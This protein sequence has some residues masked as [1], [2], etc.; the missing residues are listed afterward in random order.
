MDTNTIV[1]PESLASLQL[2]LGLTNS[3]MIFKGKW[4]ALNLC[5]EGEEWSERMARI[6]ANHLVGKDLFSVKFTEPN[7]DSFQIGARR[8]SGNCL[9]IRGEFETKDDEHGKG[10]REQFF[11]LN[12]LFT[13]ATGKT[14]FSVRSM[15]LIIKANT[16]ESL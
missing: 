11:F 6:A 14:I 12:G 2:R 5:K 15:H 7:I 10:G 3:A 4:F 9:F 8:V 13:T 16:E 1:K